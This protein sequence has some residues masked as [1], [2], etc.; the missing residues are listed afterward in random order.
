MT[1]VTATRPTDNLR[2]VLKAC[3]NKEGEGN[4]EDHIQKVFN[5]LIQHY[6]SQALEKLEEASYL[7]K[8]DQD[9]TKFMKISCNHDYSNLA[10]DLEAYSAEMQKHFA[11]PQP[12]EEGGDVPEIAPVGFVADLLADSK[13]WQ[14]AGIGFGEME[15]YRLQKS[16]K[17]L[18][19]KES[20]T[21][22]TFFGK[23]LGSEND[24]Y[25][26]EAQV[27]EAAE[28]EEGE[29]K[30]ADFEPKGTGVNRYTYYVS[31]GALSDWVKLPDLSPS[32]IKASRQIKCLF[33]GD[34][35]RKIYTNPFFEGCEKHY[36]RAQIARISH[37]TTLIPK[38]LMR[39]VEDSETREIE[40]NTPEEG[41]IVMPTTNQMKSLDMWVHATKNILL[42]GTTSL[43]QPEA[44]EG[45]E[46]DEDKTN[47]EM[48]KLLQ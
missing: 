42:N 32:Q 47:D 25:I 18:A 17:K 38:G 23:V 2:K 24:Y 5:F 1:T 40:E 34:L 37:S 14:W 30:E 15:V 13:V 27:E 44:P 22:L 4:L 46:W 35:N 9:I 10:K 48:K 21:Q 26:V 41:D 12:E 11:Q 19:A 7:L 39:P 36:L 28:E 16:L 8:T 29:E 43:K 31:T 33:T 3:A 20:A 6:P 45:E